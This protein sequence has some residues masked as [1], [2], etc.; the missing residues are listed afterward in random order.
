MKNNWTIEEIEA[1]LLEI[2]RSQRQLDD[3]FTAQSD[4]AAVGLD[5]LTMVRVL[6][7]V[8]EKFGVWLEGDVL[9]GENLKNVE[10]MSRNLKAILDEQASTPQA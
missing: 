2:I 4:L 3:T 6:I 10:M 1:G 7:S 5:S 8:E 9:S